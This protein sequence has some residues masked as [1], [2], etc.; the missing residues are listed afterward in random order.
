MSRER[1]RERGGAGGRKG[2]RESRDRVGMR[3]KTV[4]GG[5]DEHR[6]RERERGGWGGAE[7][8]LSYP[9]QAHSAPPPPLYTR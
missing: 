1:V 2:E 8:L 4:G 7:S 5:G 6:E 9:R 3:E